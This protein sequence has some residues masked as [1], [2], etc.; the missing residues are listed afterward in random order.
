MTEL[1]VGRLRVT[2]ARHFSPDDIREKLPSLAEGRVPNYREVSREI[3]AANKSSER[4]IMPSL[5]AGDTPD[6]VDVDL[7]VEDRHPLHG[8]LEINDRFPSRTE[9]LRVSAG[10]RYANMFQLGHT[11]SLQGQLAPTDPG[12][13]WSV[14]GSYVA[15]IAGSGFS[16]LGYAVKSN[17]DVS[18]VNGIGVLGT[19]EI[20]GARG[21]YSFSTGTGAATVIHQLTAGIDYK[22]FEESL[23]VGADEARTPIDYFPATVQYSAAKRTERYDLDVSLSANFGLRSLSA[24]NE[25]FGLKRFNAS[26]SWFALRTD[27]GYLHKL[28]GDWRL[29]VRLSGQLAS[30][31]LIS[32]EQFAAGGLDSVRGYF[33]SQDLG[34]DGASFQ[35]QAESPLL[36]NK[37]GPVDELRLFAFTD[38]AVLH[39]RDPLS[40]QQATTSLLSVGAGANLRLLGNLN[41][42]SL[43]AVPLKQTDGV[44]TDI[45]DTVRI[46]VRAWAEF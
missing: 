25:E 15:P 9:R 17:S 18:A 30:G 43:L 42:S 5:R 27:M 19:G 37:Q 8:S 4:L 34:D 33:E 24:T 13:S 40:S 11:L 20:Y 16:V 29:G 45:A 46:Q 22:I 7:Q 12:Q 36:L 1:K 32:N 39:L 6:T 14:S 28:R 44:K 38:G 2:N 3:A 26:A 41:L 35:L 10:L 23:I 31:A 21:I